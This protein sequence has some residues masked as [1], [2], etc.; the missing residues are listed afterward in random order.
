MGFALVGAGSSNIV[1]VMFSA[2]KQKTMPEALAVPAISTLGLFRY[3]K[4]TC[5]YWFCCFQ[6]SLATAL[7]LISALLVIIV[8]L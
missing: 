6:L 2:R 1:P 4:G 7:L 3:F 8:L 5:S